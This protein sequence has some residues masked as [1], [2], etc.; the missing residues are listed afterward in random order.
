MTSVLDSVIAPPEWRPTKL[1]SFLTRRKQTNR[2]DLQLLSV[3]LP[4]GVVPRQE[5]DGRTAPSLDLSGYQEV[6]PNDLVMNQLGKPHGALGVSHHHGIIS[7]AYF[8]AEISDEANPRFVHHL[9]RTRLYISEYERRGKCLPPSQFDISWEQFRDIPV[10]LPPLVEQQAIADYLDTETA[11]IDTLI[12]KKR[13]LIELLAE[14][15]TAL[16]TQTVTRGFDPSPRLRPSGMDWLGHIPAHWEVLRLKYRVSYR[17]SNV[18]KKTKEGELPVRLCNYTD[19]YYGNR[20]RAGDSSFMEATAS[21]QEFVR[22]RLNE[23][24]VVITK[25]SEDW[26]DIAVPALIEETADDFVCGYHLGIIRPTPLANPGFVFRAMQSDAVNCQLRVAATGI[27]RFGLPK[28]AVGEA[29][30]PFPPLDEQRDIAAFLDRQ[31]NRI[32][33][34]SSQAEAMIKL[35]EEYRTALITAAVTRDLAV[36]GLTTETLTV[37]LISP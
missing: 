3:N 14:H 24:D 25:D 31:T 6:R 17:T 16:I 27:T 20:I 30:V 37:G 13:R 8:V 18:D 33:G 34:L 21:P 15:R 23:G 7:P 5:G 26:Q 36:P 35:L 11:R 10:S 4:K 19:V 28:P 9:L 2:S 1:R 29:L 22:F 32:D 12:S